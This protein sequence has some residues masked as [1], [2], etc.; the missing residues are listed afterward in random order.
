MN[1]THGWCDLL[2]CSGASQPE[3]SHKADKDETFGEVHSESV[4]VAVKE[5][6]RRNHSR[7]TFI[8]YFKGSPPSEAIDG[9]ALPCSSDIDDCRYHCGT[10][11]RPANA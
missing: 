5:T 3:N 4:V 2:S 6:R 7:G 10:G 9:F 1:V 8:H 11:P